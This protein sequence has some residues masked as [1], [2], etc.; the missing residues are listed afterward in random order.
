MSTEEL[1]ERDDLS[2]TSDD[3]RRAERFPCGLQPVISEWG[4]ATG[5]SHMA[6]VANIS[7]TGLALLTPSRISPGR[8][9]VI[10]LMSKEGGLSR[11]ILVRVIH[12][13][14][15]PDGTW[16]SGG[17]FVRR[18]SDKEINLIVQAGGSKH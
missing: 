18:L 3:R 13:T 1:P 4:A 2:V 6:S 10:R 9:L 7:V 15:Q 12:S 17:A 16:Y 11:P 8:V 14:Q 5:E